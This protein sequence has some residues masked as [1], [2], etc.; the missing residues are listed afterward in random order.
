[1]PETPACLSFE[2][3]L[4]CQTLSNALLISKK[5]TRAHNVLIWIPQ[6]VIVWV[7]FGYTCKFFFALNS[8]VNFMV[9]WYTLQHYW[10]WHVCKFHGALVT[11]TLLYR[12]WF[13]WNQYK[14]IFF[15]PCISIELHGFVK[16]NIIWYLFTA[17][18]RFSFYYLFT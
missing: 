10:F 4:L 6:S 1:L 15:Y 16:F 3:F 7:I 17:R 5:I 14:V 12:I 9:L 11:L 2:R 18:I 13:R 8:L